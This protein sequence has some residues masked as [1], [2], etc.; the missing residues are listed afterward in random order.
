MSTRLII[1]LKSMREG[2][3]RLASVLDAVGRAE[4][5]DRLLVHTLEQAAHFP[6]LERTFVLSPCPA[7]RKRAQMLGAC[8]LDEQASGL[9][10]AL[11]RAC[12]AMRDRTAA[13]VLVIPCD[14][15]FLSADDLRALAD[16]ASSPAIALAPDRHRI[17]TNGIGLPASSAFE[18]CFGPHSFERHRAQSRSLQLPAIEVHRDGLAFDV[19]TPA[20]LMQ[21]QSDV[22]ESRRAA[23][24]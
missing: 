2:K 6:G 14:L 22:P 12:S 8:A 21:S 16:V 10:A 9:N 4:L 24:R 1:P 3:T 7:A 17:G 13:D 23:G 19:D 18:F 15:P 5:I 20:D 11:Q